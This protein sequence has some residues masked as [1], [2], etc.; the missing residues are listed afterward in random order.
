MKRFLL[1]GVAVFALAACGQN[2]DQQSG[3]EAD[4]TEM[5][6]ATTTPELG[7][8]GVDLAD[9]DPEVDP[10][11]DF[12]R[13]VNG[14][15]LDTFEIP[16]EFSSYGSFTVLFER[17]E[18]RVKSII[19]DAAK[20]DARPGS[21]EQKIGEYY[22]SF[23]DIAAIDAKGFAVV[24]DDFAKIDAAQNHEDIAALLGNP[25]IG[26]DSPVGAFISV[27]SKQTDQYAVYLTQ[28]GL[29]MPNRD[30]YLDDKFADKRPKYLAYIEKALTLAGV[31]DAAAKAQAIL[32]VETKMAEAHWEPAK[33]R[34]RDLTYNLKTRDELEAFAPEMP[35]DAAFDAAGLGD[36]SSFIVREDDAIQNLAKIFAETPV[37]TWK[38]YMKFHLLNA[39]SAA[40]RRAYCQNKW[41]ERSKGNM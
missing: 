30:Y 31:D 38:A 34:N 22:A 15:W 25:R 6:A 41:L 16:E 1:C 13:Y 5:A 27:D 11:D 10:G 39:N 7:D 4:K 2:K 36:V 17:S 3:A 18:D 29:G 33:R 12:F 8:F 26:A 21:L 40:P 23:L 28:A 19:E 14:K 32:D 35:W 24:A 37:E 9:I 20:S